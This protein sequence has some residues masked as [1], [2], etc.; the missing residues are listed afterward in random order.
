MPLH[1]IICARKQYMLLS[2]QQDKGLKQGA[3]HQCNCSLKWFWTGI[4]SEIWYPFDQNWE[5][6]ISISHNHY[7]QLKAEHE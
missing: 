7:W 4:V 2:H 1:G 3:F 5:N 6:A